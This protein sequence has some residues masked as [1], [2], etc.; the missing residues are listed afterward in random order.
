MRI[1][2]PII[3]QD[4]PCKNTELPNAATVL[5][6]RLILRLAGNVGI[7]DHWG[8]QKPFSNFV[9]S[10]KTI[11]RIMLQFSE[12]SQRKKGPSFHNLTFLLNDFTLSPLNHVSSRVS[13]TTLTSKTA[14]CLPTYLDKY[15]LNETSSLL[16]CT[17]RKIKY[18]VT[19]I[20]QMRRTIFHLLRFIQ[21]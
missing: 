2:A 12:L 5:K 6:W 13:W 10:L 9:W 17:S 16:Q 3:W 18:N 20:S 8:K 11:K 19:V 14:W 21:P 1:Q 7:S 15:C 4:F